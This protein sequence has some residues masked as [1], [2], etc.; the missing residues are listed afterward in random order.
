MIN[1][2]R[3][4]NRAARTTAAPA[5][6]S[7]NAAR[8]AYLASVKLEQMPEP[9]VHAGAECA[10]RIQGFI[11]ELNERFEKALSSYPTVEKLTAGE[12]TV[13]GAP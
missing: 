7:E 9:N 4:A 2:Y 5:Y 3:D 8:L 12:E 6:F 10:N 11:Q 1:L 13:R